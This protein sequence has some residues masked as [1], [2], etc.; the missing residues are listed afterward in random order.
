[1]AS[2]PELVEMMKE[3]ELDYKNKSIE[4]MMQEVKD[5]SD[6]LF[7]KDYRIPWTAASDTL[8]K[9]LTTEY[10]YFVRSK[11]G[12]IKRDYMGERI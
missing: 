10:D 11:R 4:D 12:S 3:L 9:F 7:D 2:R 8:R 6:K 5:A 1:M